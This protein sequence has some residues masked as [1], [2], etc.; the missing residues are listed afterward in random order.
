MKCWIFRFSVD[1]YHYI[2]KIN[3]LD[4]GSL[5]C[6]FGASGFGIF[7]ESGLRSLGKQR[8]R[9]GQGI[10][11]VDL[12]AYFR[13]VTGCGFMMYFNRL[14]VR[15]SRFMMQIILRID[16][17]DSVIGYLHIFQLEIFVYLIRNWGKKFVSPSVLY[18][19]NIGN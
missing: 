13:R 16:F 15:E 19:Y 4:C 18:V 6:T 17:S 9:P 1:I 10:R 7:G 8:Q 11:P 3:V 2:N 12:V 5:T 14:F